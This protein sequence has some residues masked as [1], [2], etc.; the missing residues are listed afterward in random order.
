MFKVLSAQMMEEQIT[1]DEYRSL[2]QKTSG[3][4]KSKTKTTI[5]EFKDTGRAR[6]K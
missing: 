2:A 6:K 1:E 3:M 5:R 4:L